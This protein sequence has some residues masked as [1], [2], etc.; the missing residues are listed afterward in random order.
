[1]DHRF[2]LS[3]VL[4][5]T[6]RR[7]EKNSHDDDDDRRRHPHHHAKSVRSMSSGEFLNQRSNRSVLADGRRRLTFGWIT[8]L[9]RMMMDRFQAEV[10]VEMFGAVLRIDVPTQIDLSLEGAQ[11]FMALKRFEARM[12]SAVCNQI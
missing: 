2:L 12:F 1:M 8:V 4:F 5:C 10:S 6:A 3:L 7:I 9:M 11:T